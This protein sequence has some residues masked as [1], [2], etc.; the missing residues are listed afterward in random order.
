MTKVIPSIIPQTREQM[1]EEI[2]R[3]ARFAP[4]IQIDIS[5]GLFTPV[6]TWPYNGE[7][8]DF[9][10][11][12]K[13]EIIG[14][15][16]WEDVEFEVHLMI[17]D[18]E[19]TVGDWIKAGVSAV[20]VNIESTNNFQKII[21]TCRGASV[22]LGIAIKPGTNIENIKPFVSQVDFIQVMG[23]D[24]LGK[25][26]VPLDF[27][28]VDQIKSL[29]KLYPDSIIAIDIGV[30]ADTVETL[31]RAGASK[32]ISGGDILEAANPEEVFKYFQ[33]FN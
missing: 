24:L 2:R 9:F 11:N 6:K 29:R 19:E 23:S 25:H 28:A 17:K 27:K 31:V 32:L 7:D 8:E 22:S 3:V 4:L 30:T 21:D 12:L 26:N 16:K 1:E 33:S 15:P 5:D 10:E 14:F 20:V 13:N 18:P